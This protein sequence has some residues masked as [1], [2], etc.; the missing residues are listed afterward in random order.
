MNIS[1]QTF[2]TKNV[3][4]GKLK[5]LNFDNFDNSHNSFLWPEYFIDYLMWKMDPMSGFDIR[6]VFT[7]PP[8]DSTLQYK[9][10]FPCIKSL[11]C[12]EVSEVSSFA[13][14]SVCILCSFHQTLHV[15]CKST[16][17]IVHYT[18]HVCWHEGNRI[19]RICREKI[20]SG[21]SLIACKYDAATP[22]FA[23]MS[24]VML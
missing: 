21:Y 23:L 17:Y 13:G 10:C 5:T 8:S 12:T 22:A 11:F 15:D 4:K 18:F 2:C 20:L 9:R 16:L 24:K 7:I 1:K 3:M 6:L 19:H 14:Y